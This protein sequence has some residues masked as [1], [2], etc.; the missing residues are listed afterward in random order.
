MQTATRARVSLALMLAVLRLG[1][2]S[3]PEDLAAA[4][5]ARGAGWTGGRCV[6]GVN[7]TGGA[8]V[9]GALDPFGTPAPTLDWLLDAASSATA[10]V[11]REDWRDGLGFAEKDPPASDAEVAAL[12]ALD[13]AAFAAVPPRARRRAVAASARH[14]WRGYR[15][16]AWPSDELAPVA[17]K[18]VAWLD[19]GLTIVDALDTLL[20]VGL[21]EEAATARDWI[22]SPALAFDADKNA[23]VFESTIRVLG[24]LAAAREL[25]GDTERGDLLAKA[26]DLAEKLSPAFKTR[27][28]I[29]IMDVNFKTG[30]PHHPKW[31][32]KSSLAEA[33]T[34]VLEW[35]ALE[36]AL[37]A[38]ENTTAGGADAADAAD[39]AHDG[40]LGSREAEMEYGFCPDGGGLKEYPIDPSGPSC[41][42][43]SNDAFARSNLA[44]LAGRRYRRDIAIGARRAFHAVTDATWLPANDGLVPNAVSSGT[45]VFD[46]AS[47]LTLGARGDSYYEYLLKHWLHAGKPAGGERSYLR[48]MDGVLLYL[49]R[50]ARSGAEGAETTLGLRKSAEANALGLRWG[51]TEPA[52]RATSS[53]RRRRRRWFDADDEAQSDAEEGGAKTED[54]PP[55][56]NAFEDP[57]SVPAVSSAGAAEETAAFSGRG[58]AAS[59][60]TEEASGSNTSVG[61]G[62]LYVAERVGGVAG[63]L[64]H[65]MDHLVCFLPG[66]LALGH[67]EGLGA[68]WGAGDAARERLAGEALARLGFARDAGHLDVAVELARTC[69]SMYTRVP[70]GL[71]P[72][73]A[74]FPASGLRA[75]GAGPEE[76]HAF[77]DLLVKRKDAHNL[78]RPETVES[79]F[80]L[81]RVTRSEEWRAAG[82]EMWRAWER[83]ARVDTGGYA[84]V[85][86]VVDPESVRRWNRFA[87]SP[88]P[89]RDETSASS[90]GLGED[91]LQNTP[92]RSKT[93]DRELNRVDKMESFWLSETLKYLFL[94]FTDD[95]TV[96]PLECFVFNTEAHP[97]PVL[98]A[99][100]SDARACVERVAAR[101]ARSLAAMQGVETHE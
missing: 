65:K 76:V 92:K 28:G 37:R 42:F 13:D 56:T 30:D 31:T 26:L 95:P 9:P 21:E 40:T 60:A 67:A 8:C 101:H 15:E 59:A 75:G 83:H 29:P 32:Q 72:E 71:A 70:A 73:I 2:C 4:A 85:D 33:G 94:L 34:L 17:R 97:L 52:P 80:V 69:V 79:L 93:R 20:I 6:D 62:S 96:L 39:G 100:V 43:E 82:W 63:T 44:A 16:H 18:G 54:A 22:A 10:R 35:E 55:A 77:G 61:F 14:A 38:A 12:L 36:A 66:V 5:A 74:H 78:L 98:R 24:G 7:A 51:V 89:S 87:E 90:A 23:N 68:R 1:A 99:G 84:G 81:W 46:R 45:A 64:V 49:L 50:R 91:S 57:L 48:A 19:V 53:A 3:S 27:T 11:P 47:T 88:T 41:D 86:S 25:G 58:E